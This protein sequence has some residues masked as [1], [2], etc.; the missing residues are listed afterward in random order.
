MLANMGVG[1]FIFVGS[2]LLLSGCAS[3]GGFG[4]VEPDESPVV[5]SAVEL[6]DRV[7]CAGGGAGYPG[8]DDITLSAGLAHTPTL[9]GWTE[10][11][12][13][14]VHIEASGGFAVGDLDDDGLL[15][16]VFTSFEAPLYVFY[17]TGPMQ[18]RPV[19][20][21]EHGV[22]TGGALSNSLTAVDV[23]GDGDLDLYL[24]TLTGGSLWRNRGD[25]T[26]EPAPE[27]G[28]DCP[29][30]VLGSTWADVDRDGD[31]DAFIYTHGDSTEGSDAFQNHPDFLFENDEGEFLDRSGRLPGLNEPAGQAFAAGWFDADGDLLPDLVVVNDG[32][33]W[34]GNPRNRYYANR[35]DWTFEAVEGYADQGMLAMGLAIGDLDN[36]GDADLHVTD[37]GPTRLLRNEGDHVFT[38]VS[39]SVSAFTSAERGD[40]SWGTT[41]L[42]HDADGVLELATA[43]GHMPSKG[44]GGGPDATS[45]RLD[46][47]D[48]VWARSGETWTDIAAELGVANPAW[49]RA[50]LS[51]DLDRDGF[52]DLV[53][54][55]LDGGP[56]VHHARCNGNAW[57]RVRLEQPGPNKG[58]IG[59]R[60]E[61]FP[62]DGPLVM[63][64]MR[65][66]GEGTLSG[67]PP[68]VLLGLGEADRVDVRVVWPDGTDQLYRSIPTRRGVTI[69]HPMLVAEHAEA[70][71]V[72]GAAAAS[73]R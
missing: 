11:D 64:E 35:G 2:V 15:D 44:V 58:A 47:P 19:P 43:Y 31:L 37:A 65:L 21:E 60:I 5:S 20:L 69:R 46:M 30:N 14:S 9:P 48:Q 73:A 59:A 1:R 49:T 24:G 23:E 22:D 71:A 27:V 55:S 38:D 34:E 45:N 16:L 33:I 40:I 39:L 41:F 67:G 72:R 70:P 54:F 18:W 10:D 42:D 7:D 28:L 25:G 4:G 62:T 66:G 8:Y 32:G 12:R 3:E 51:E 29:G 50:I 6:E 68:E 36:D 17:S 26:F 61:A 57:I 52:A 56:R 13:T 63:R 53:T